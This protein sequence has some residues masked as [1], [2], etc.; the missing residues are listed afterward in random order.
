MFAAQ[1][2]SNIKTKTHLSQNFL[3]DKQIIGRIIKTI[4]PKK[5]DNLVEIGPG[6]G[7]LSR[8]LL[9]HLEQLHAIEID[10]E[11]VAHLKK[12][13]S[14]NLKLYCADVLAFNF[15]NLPAPLRIVG[16]LPYHISSPILF[17]IQKY[18]MHIKDIHFMLQ[19][20][21]A[22]RVVAIKGSKTYGRLSVM[23]QLYFEVAFLFKVP[24][25]AFYP[26]PQVESAMIYLKPKKPEGDI[27]RAL[28]EKVVKA[29]FSTR[30]KILRN[31]LKSLIR[32]EATRIDLSQRAE[33]LSLSDFI[34]LTN[35]I[36]Q[37]KNTKKL[38]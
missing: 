1:K 14:S 3:I 4:C 29:A 9:M 7:A 32:A 15:A 23:M 36:A 33:S 19:K 8:E 25:G 26:Q 11:L 22:D 27:D 2:K 24:H 35:D 13:N 18:H 37:A 31:C 28:F 34:I 6:L 10:R 30:R 5:N 17:K 20:E 21:V 38:T 12:N 16:N